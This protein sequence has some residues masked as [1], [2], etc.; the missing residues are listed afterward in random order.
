M[1][2]TST[3]APSRAR[4]RAWDAPWPRAA[5]VT[6]ATF[7]SSSICSLIS[8]SRRVRPLRAAMDGRALDRANAPES[9][10]EE[11]HRVFGFVLYMQREDL[12][13]DQLVAARV[14]RRAH[15]EGVPE[16]SPVKG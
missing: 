15:P 5:P 13:D 3:R 11:D 7:P 4:W 9:A 6:M 16:R 8:L 2:V 12:Q 10:S 14:M 1:S